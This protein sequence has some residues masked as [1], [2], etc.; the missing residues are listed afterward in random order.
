MMINNYVI[1]LCI[2]YLM[3]L[4]IILVYSFYL[5]KVYDKAYRRLYAYKVYYKAWHIIPKAASYV[6]S[7]LYFLTI[8]KKSH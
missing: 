1:G 2:Y 7:L 3:F 4:I 5:S 6:S 8:S